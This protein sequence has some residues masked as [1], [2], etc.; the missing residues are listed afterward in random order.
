VRIA[1]EANPAYQFDQRRK[2]EQVV[3]TDHKG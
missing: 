2:E 3:L 1:K